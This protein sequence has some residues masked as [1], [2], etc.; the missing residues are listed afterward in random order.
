M[1][2]RET[3][4][5]REEGRY[6]GEA[7]PGGVASMFG[8]RNLKEQRQ[9]RG[10]QGSVCEEEFVRILLPCRLLLPLLPSDAVLGACPRQALH[11]VYTSDKLNFQKLAS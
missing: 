4:A 1:A 10:R 8:E 9:T 6:P 2:A 3:E 7:E 5:R 11:P